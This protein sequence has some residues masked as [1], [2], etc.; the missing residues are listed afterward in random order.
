MTLTLQTKSR[1]FRSI[2]AHGD[3]RYL[4]TERQYARADIANEFSVGFHGAERLKASS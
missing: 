2:P 1:L 3:G 4:G